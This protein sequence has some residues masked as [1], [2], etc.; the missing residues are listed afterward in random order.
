MRSKHIPISGLMTTITITITITN[1]FLLLVPQFRWTTR[2]PGLRVGSS[3]P[4][5]TG[6]WVPGGYT[7]SCAESMALRLF[8]HLIFTAFSSQKCQHSDSKWHKLAI[9]LRFQ[10]TSGTKPSLFSTWLWWVPGWEYKTMEVRGEKGR[11]FCQWINKGQQC[12]DDWPSFLSWTST[13][14]PWYGAYNLVLRASILLS[15][16]RLYTVSCVLIALLFVSYLSLA[17]QHY[18]TWLTIVYSKRFE[19]SQY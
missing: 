11:T 6:T 18:T 15:G 13:Y 8:S 1:A 16:V 14:R 3:A 9:V 2:P 7:R 17:S 19:A 10:G 4:S 12:C 5:E